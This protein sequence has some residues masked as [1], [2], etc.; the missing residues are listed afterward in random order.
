MLLF[1]GWGRAQHIRRQPT[2][3]SALNL[4]PPL[5]CLYL[6]ALFPILAGPFGN[7]IRWYASAPLVIYLLAM[8]GQ[9]LISIRSAG[10]A[11]AV[12]AMPLLVVT[13]LFYGVGFLSGI[14]RAPDR[15]AARTSPEVQLERVS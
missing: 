9:T 6:L 13:H 12:L 7:S 4:A 10:A 8:V 1:Y 11:C 14:F 15:A 3:G 5:L 2:I